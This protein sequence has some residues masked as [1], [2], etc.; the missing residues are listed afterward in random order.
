M[1][2]Y[3]G[4]YSNTVVFFKKINNLWIRENVVKSDTIFKTFTYDIIGNIDNSIP[5]YFEKGINCYGD[6]ESK[7]SEISKEFMKIAEE[8]YDI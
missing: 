4:E 5:V 3:I 2:R 7:L 1:I 8:S 6:A